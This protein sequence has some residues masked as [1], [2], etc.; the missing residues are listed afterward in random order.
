FC[1]AAIRG[2]LSRLT[3]AKAGAHGIT[4]PPHNF[5]MSARTMPF[6]IDYTVDNKRAVRSESPAAAMMARSLFVI[7]IQSRPRNMAMSS[8]L[9][10]NRIWCGTDD[11]L[12]HLTT[13]GGKTWNDVTPPAISAWQKIS[14][15]DAGHFDANAAYAAVNTLRLDDVRPHIYRTHDG[16]KRWTEIV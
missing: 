2:R 14:I 1:S 4:S 9:D 3:A 8:P 16:G 6:P 10:V 15:I 7:G 12:I 13:N 11:G 5:I